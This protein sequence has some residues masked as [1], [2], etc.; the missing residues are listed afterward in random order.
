MRFT[1]KI[2]NIAYL[3]GCIMI[4]MI[5]SSCGDDDIKVGNEEWYAVEYEI[6]VN[7]S[8]FIAEGHHHLNIPQEGMTLV[9]SPTNKHS[10]QDWW[11]VDLMVLYENNGDGMNSI[12]YSNMND[13]NRKNPIEGDWGSVIFEWSEKYHMSKVIINIAPNESNI[14]REIFITAAT[15]PFGTGVLR[16]TQATN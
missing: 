11:S 5:S 8:S 4:S 2:Q 15:S 10:Q 9:L 6:S 3:L 14:V 16:L 13:E 1:N 7:G 12:Y